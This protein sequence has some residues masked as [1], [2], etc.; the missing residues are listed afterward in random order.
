MNLIKQI[1]KPA[2]IKFL[3]TIL[4]S[5][6]GWFMIY[7]LWLLPDGRLDAFLASNIVSVSG[8]LLQLMEFDPYVTSTLIGLGEARGIKMVEACT[9]VQLMGLFVGFIV[10][11]PG[12]IWAKLNYIFIGIGIMYLINVVRLT[13]LAIAQVY[14]PEWFYFIHD[15][16]SI[17]IFY[18][19]IFA[20]WIVW[21]KIQEND[22]SNL[23]S[24]EKELV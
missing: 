5:F 15:K 16:L 23:L 13:V 21:V 2:V 20:L 11:Y 7:E 17:Q 14:Y 4:A 18:I 9:G 22:R 8:G 6:V 12:K 1:K 24:Y 3:A 19:T 10:A